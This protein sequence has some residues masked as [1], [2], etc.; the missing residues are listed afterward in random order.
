[1][2]YSFLSPIQQIEVHASPS[3]YYPIIYNTSPPTVSAAPTIYT[4]PSPTV[5]A[6]P[7]IYNTPPPTVSA[8]STI[9]TTPP[10][11]YSPINSTTSPTN[12]SIQSTKTNN[13]TSQQIIDS[14]NL[15]RNNTNPRAKN[16]KD[17]RWSDDLAQS[18][19]QW[20][21][22]CKWQHSNTK[23]VGENLYAT[24]I[25]NKNFDPSIAVKSWGDEG[26][27]YNYNNNSCQKGKQCGH[28]TQVVWANSDKVGCA[29]NTCDKLDGSGFPSGGTF[30]VCQYS[31]PGNYVNQKPYAT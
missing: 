19:M 20:A 8:P 18:S 21:K 25:K 27:Y 9:Y 17:I 14:H 28:Y 16:M 6:A 3:Q 29:I 31:P 2:N 1:M 4:T 13:D 30:V 22:Q 10:F 24:T 11:I 12:A 5:S 23:N 15:Y 7:I 26:E